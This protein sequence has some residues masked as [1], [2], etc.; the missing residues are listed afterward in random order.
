MQDGRK[1]W[2][3]V[4]FKII[5]NYI[6]NCKHYYGLDLLYKRTRLIFKV[7]SHKNTIPVQFFIFFI[8]IQILFYRMKSKLI[9]KGGIKCT[10]YNITQKHENI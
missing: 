6:K 1:L 9:W 10:I 3:G 7:M 2:H 8:I 5:F 4:S